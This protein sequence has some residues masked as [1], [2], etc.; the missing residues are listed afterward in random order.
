MQEK[1]IRNYR[2][3]ELYNNN[4]E[5]K[6]KRIYTNL[7]SG[8]KRFLKMATDEHLLELEKLLNQEKKSRKL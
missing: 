3:R 4:E 8:S 6:K 1:Y 7:K 2:D 5:T